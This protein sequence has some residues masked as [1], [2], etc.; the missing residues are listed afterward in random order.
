MFG[1][2]MPVLRMKLGDPRTS[3]DLVYCIDGKVHLSATERDSTV[4][5]SSVQ[6]ST[7][8][9][10]RVEYS[11]T[12]QD[13]TAHRSDGRNESSVY[14]EISEQYQEL[15]S[16]R[17][18]HEIDINRAAGDVLR[19]VSCSDLQL[20]DEI[21]LSSYGVCSDENGR[22]TVVTLSVRV[23]NNKCV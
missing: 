17:N 14:S 21:D 23:R 7:Y 10:S 6:Y 4:Q 13:E 15:R 2:A 3:V 9:V 20:R 8:V 1:I 19:A 22:Y 11:T 16:A 12:H 5:F 18:R